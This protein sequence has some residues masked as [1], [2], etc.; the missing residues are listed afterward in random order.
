[1]L[2]SLLL[3]TAL[4]SQTPQTFDLSPSADA[5]V[6][7][8]SSDPGGEKL[9]RIWG[10]GSE[11]VDKVFPSGGEFAYGYLVFDVPKLTDGTRYKVSS[12]SMVVFAQANEELT[13]A[14]FKEFP[15]EV[16]G[17]EKTFEEKTFHI[18]TFKEGPYAG[19]FGQAVTAEKVGDNLKFTIDLLGKDSEFADW[20]NVGARTGKFAISLTSKISPAESRSMIYKVF[21]KEND[22]ALVPKLI[23][24]VQ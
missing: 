18:D 19:I 13:P 10:D 3:G 5:W 17:L 2:S 16:R 14:I 9:M 7:P 24:K 11:S 15:L 1:M 22:K 21:T 20:F 8:H 23:V 6:Y 4:L 12:A